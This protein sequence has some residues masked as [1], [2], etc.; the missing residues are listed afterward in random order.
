ML[1]APKL[2]YLSIQYPYHNVAI[3]T[4]MQSQFL[5][6]TKTTSFGSGACTMKFR[7]TD[8]KLQIE[9]NEKTYNK[10]NEGNINTNMR[11]NK[12][13]NKIFDNSTKQTIEL[14]E[15]QLSENNIQDYTII[16]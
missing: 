10:N 6:G 9:I 12:I 2:L 13:V 15:M 5:S 16:E 1:M 4:L 7:S 11:D 14:Q 8:N 3:A